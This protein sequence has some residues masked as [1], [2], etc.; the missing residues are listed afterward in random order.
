MANGLIEDCII[1]GGALGSSNSTIAQQ[2]GNVY[3]TGGVV[4]RCKILNGKATLIKNSD[5]RTFVAAGNICVFGNTGSIPVIENC[6]ISG[7]YGY[8]YV[9]T[10]ATCRAKAGNIY[11]NGSCRIVNCT[12]ING[13]GNGVGGV[14]VNYNSVYTDCKIVNCIMYNNGG[15]T[16]RLYKDWGSD[17]NKT[18]GYFINCAIG[19]ATKPNATCI[20]VDKTAFENFDGGDCRLRKKDPFSPLINAGTSRPEYLKYASSTTDLSG[21]MRFSGKLD[22]GCYECSLGGFSVIVR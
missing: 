13:S 6:F 21:S 14:A 12:I 2:G 17:N 10:V 22:I 5:Y 20:G 8:G 9:N 11:I 4:R 19:N 3:I 1:T 16:A 7:G 15:N 18:Y